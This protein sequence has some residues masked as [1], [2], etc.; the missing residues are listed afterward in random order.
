MFYSLSFNCTSIS[1]IGTNFIQHCYSHGYICVASLDYVV[2]G[3][4]HYHMEFKPRHEIHAKY[5][6][7]KFSLNYLSPNDFHVLMRTVDK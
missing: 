7:R 5:F 3:C 1:L 2:N 4:K 6:V